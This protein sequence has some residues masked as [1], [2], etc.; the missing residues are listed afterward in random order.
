MVPFFRFIG[1]EKLKSC[2][3]KVVMSYFGKVK[4][5]YSNK[6]IG[7]ENGVEIEHKRVRSFGHCEANQK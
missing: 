1:K 4:M 7:H 5:S 3:G 6:R 2:K